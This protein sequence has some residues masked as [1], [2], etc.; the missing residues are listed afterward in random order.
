MDA[1]CDFSNYQEYLRGENR[2]KS[3]N[4]INKEEVNDLLRLNEEN[5]K[6]RYD[7]YV[8]LL[9]NKKSS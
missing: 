9:N 4:K 2:Y 8:S 3:L 7:Y 6:K 5:A 1:K